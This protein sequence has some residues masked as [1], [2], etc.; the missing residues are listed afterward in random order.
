MGAS[1][2]QGTHHD[3]QTLS[4][5]ALPLK[6]LSE[7]VVCL[8][9]VFKAARVKVGAGCPTS[10]STVVVRPVVRVCAGVRSCVHS[11]ASSPIFKRLTTTNIMMLRLRLF[12]R[13]GV[14]AINRVPSGA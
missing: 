2:L 9:G 5:I 4:T 13:A 1:W 3:A 8:V 7:S 11:K 6:S 12:L 14:D 10:G